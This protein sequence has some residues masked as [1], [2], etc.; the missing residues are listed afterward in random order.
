MSSNSKPRDST[1]GESS[2]SIIVTK[3]SRSLTYTVASFVNSALPLTVV[4]TMNSVDLLLV[5]FEQKSVHSCSPYGE[6]RHCPNIYIYT[7]VYVDHHARNLTEMRQH[8]TEL[9]CSV[10]GRLVRMPGH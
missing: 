9:F 8:S 5:L 10:V 1:A 4:M 6:M 7:Y 3:T 2:N